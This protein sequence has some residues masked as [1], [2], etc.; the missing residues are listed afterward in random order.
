MRRECGARIQPQVKNRELFQQPYKENCSAEVL[1][2][3]PI[4][5]EDVKRVLYEFQKKKG[6]QLT[7]TTQEQ[8]GGSNR[9]GRC[10]GHLPDLQLN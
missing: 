10:K 5:K 9:G 7:T 4:D 6:K 2:E 1:L 3:D 8:T